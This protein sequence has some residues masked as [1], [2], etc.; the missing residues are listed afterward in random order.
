[1]PSRHLYTV[2]IT[3][4]NDEVVNIS[5]RT[6]APQNEGSVRAIYTFGLRRGVPW[7][8]APHAWP[9]IE[10]GQIERECISSLLLLPLSQPGIPQL[11][12]CSLGHKYLL[13]SLASRTS[14][15]GFPPAA[16]YPERLKYLETSACSGSI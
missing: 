12:R 6:P 5:C 4:R 7:T 2:S 14:P 9:G 15:P 8:S 3:T 10:K 13:E 1:M 11:H 16:R